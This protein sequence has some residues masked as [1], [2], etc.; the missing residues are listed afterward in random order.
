MR[1]FAYCL[2]SVR[3]Q[4]I[5]HKLKCGSFVYRM[6][7]LQSQGKTFWPEQVSFAPYC[8][9]ELCIYFFLQ[10]N[11]HWAL[12]CG[13]WDSYKALVAVFIVLW[14]SVHNIFAHQGNC[15]PPSSKYFICSIQHEGKSL[16]GTEL[17]QK[18]SVDLLLQQSPPGAS[19]SMESFLKGLKHLQQ[20]PRV[21]QQN[22]QG[23][24]MNNYVHL[25]RDNG[26][27]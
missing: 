11:A 17:I 6:V 23:I 14:F 26:K 7:L 22:K 9:I 16:S 20:M 5:S 4:A 27:F 19:I 3:R 24:M 18:V 8:F 1:P 25:K 10:K 12:Y 15:S 2:C 21:K 13:K